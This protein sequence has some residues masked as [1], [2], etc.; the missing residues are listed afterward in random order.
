[1]TKQEKFLFFAARLFLGGIYIY[2]GF[3]KLVE[4]IENFRGAIA[5]YEL[6]PESL[7]ALVSYVLPWIELV[8]GFFL[9]LGYLAQLSALILSV[10]SIAFVILMGI[11]YKLHGHL[12][13]S[14]GCFGAGGF[15]LSPNLV[16]FLDLFNCLLGLKLFFTKNHPLSL[17]A[18]LDTSK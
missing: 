1:M 3:I 10:V 16:I 2:A 18:R 6:L 12:P 15:H 14:C 11:S 5:S 13:A 4:P 9:I 8:F 7:I 17:D